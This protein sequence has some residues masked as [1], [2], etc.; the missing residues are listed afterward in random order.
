MFP[1]SKNNTSPE[2]SDFTKPIVGFAGLTHLGLNSAVAGAAYGFNIIGYHNDLELINQLNSSIPHVLEPGLTE[3]LTENQSKIT[4]SADPKILNQCDI[5]YIAVDVPT[6]D[7]GV[8]DLTPIHS[9]ID[10]ATAIMHK[11]TLLVILCQ[12]PPGFSRQIKWPENQLFY[13]VETL[14]F[15]R[16]VERAMYPE[17]YIIG[18]AN[19][20]LPIDKRFLNY[21]QAFSCPILPMRYESAELAKISINMCLVASVTTANTLAEICENIGADW[22]EIVPALRLDKRIGQYS[23][24]T[25]GLGISGGNL[26]RDLETVLRY[27]EKHNTD[28]GVVQ[29]WVKN[30]YHRKDWPW[31][32]FQQLGLDKKKN[33]TISVLGLTYK[34]NTHSLKNSPSLEF[35][36]H[37][38]D[39]KVLAYDPAAPPEAAGQYVVRKISA[40]DAIKGADVLA[41]LTPWPEF[42]SISTE[43][44]EKTMTGKI[45]IDPY[46]M[47]DGDYLN[48]KG[49]IYATLGASVKK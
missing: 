38:S 32:T 2:N 42:R 12:V 9:M 8:S 17:R 1:I 28:G 49:F 35:L 14:I 6:N 46:K 45:I 33:I 22:S 41:I 16:A 31:K 36:K 44:I 4:F 47:L 37:L 34:E 3:L 27:A 15:G 19:P 23:Y 7:H 13:Q 29:S 25:P 43:I 26:E 30:S 40:I 21:L 20:A 18:C 10:M 39:R 24:L 11:E 48:A 5:V